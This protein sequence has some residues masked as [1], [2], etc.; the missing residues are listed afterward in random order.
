MKQDTENNTECEDK[1]QKIIPSARHKTIKKQ[2][3]T[4]NI[5]KKWN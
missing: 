2:N 3:P 4:L 1:K 5:V